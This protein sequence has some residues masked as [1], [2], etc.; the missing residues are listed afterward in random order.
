MFQ[1][2]GHQ[3]GVLLIQFISDT[4]HLES[5]GTPA[6]AQSHNTAFTSDTSW[7]SQVATYTSDQPINAGFL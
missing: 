2:F 6:D 3:L 4:N 7:K 1:L 5:A